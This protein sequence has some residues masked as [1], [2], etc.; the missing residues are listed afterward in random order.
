MATETMPPS[1]TCEIEAR[2]EWILRLLYATDENDESRPVYG[3]TRLMMATFLLQRKLRENF[4]K[5][6]GFEF[7]AGKFGPHDEGVLDAL[8]C[9]AEYGYVERTP[10]ALHD[11]EYEGDEFRLTP[12]GEQ[13]AKR[14]FDRLSEGEQ[15]LVHWVK[16]KQSVRSL[17]ALLSYVYMEYPRMTADSGSI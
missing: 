14:F 5:T 4:E 8:D 10:E 3:E 9:L 17:G 13:E 6:A 16:Y 1:R 7:T 2:E 12:K 11:S 15:K